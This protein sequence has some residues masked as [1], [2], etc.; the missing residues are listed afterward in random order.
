MAGQPSGHRLTNG[1]LVDIHGSERL[2]RSFAIGVGTGGI[3]VGLRWRSPVGPLRVDIAH[4]LNS[5]DSPI[6][7]TLNLGAEL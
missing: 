7:I 5:P 4:G 6:Q 2:A 3:G 1:A